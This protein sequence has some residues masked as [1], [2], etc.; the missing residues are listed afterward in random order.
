MQAPHPYQVVCGCVDKS[1]LQTKIERQCAE[2]SGRQGLELELGK[3]WPPPAPG[4][5]LALG[6]TSV[7]GRPVNFQLKAIHGTGSTRGHPT[8][9][10]VTQNSGRAL[11]PM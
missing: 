2:W 3:S 1:T 6:Y 11:F 10:Q 8:G 4:V 7:F 5:A 9:F